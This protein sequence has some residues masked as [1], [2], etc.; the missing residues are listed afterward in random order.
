MLNIYLK[1]ILTNIL[2]WYRQTFVVTADYD[3][4]ACRY[5]HFNMNLFQ[6]KFLFFFHDN[7]D[8]ED[9]KGDTGICDIL[10][11]LR[12]ALPEHAELENIYY[13]ENSINVVYVEH[14]FVFDI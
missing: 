4:K 11:W 2:Q 3:M 13:F 14:V 8:W 1:N 10:S 12:I 7:I 9:L 5:V 6:T